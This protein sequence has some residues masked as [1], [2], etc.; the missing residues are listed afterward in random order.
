MKRIALISVGLLAFLAFNVWDQISQNVEDT[1]YESTAPLVPNWAAIAGWPSADMSRVEATPDPGRRYTAIILDD[2]GSMGSDMEPAKRAV[3]EALGAMQPQ[4]RVA[5]IGLNWGVI[6]DFTAV[7]EARRT[8]PDALRPVL[9]DGPT[10]L[11]RAV[12]VARRG[13][14]SEA[15]QARGFGTYQMI[16][17][18]DGDADDGVSLT[19]AIEDLARTTPIQIATIGIGISG[20]HV[21]RRDDLGRF[22]DV[23]NVSGLQDALQAAVAEN[24]S[25][26]A[27]TDFQGSE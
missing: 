4:D 10:P 16:I 8:L 20:R 2:S 11:T 24:A 19:M 5:V 6:L 22:V 21:L 17:T 25:F 27:I 14:E 26:E 3:I 18:T 9:S 12:Q 23:S 1:V 13:L 7:E 15:A